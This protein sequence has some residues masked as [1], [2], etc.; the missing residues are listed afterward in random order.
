MNRINIVSLASASLFLSLMFVACSGDSGLTASDANISEVKTTLELDKCIDSLLGKTV[1]VIEEDAYYTCIEETWI[2][3]DVNGKSSSSKQKS[4]SSKEKTSSSK[5]KSSSSSELKVVYG[6]LTDIRDKRTYKTVT[7]GSQTWMAENL[8]YDD[9]AAT[10]SLK[11]KSWCYDNI[12]ANC[13][14]TGRLYTWAAA[15]DSVKLAND[16]EKS[17]IC[18]YGVSCTLPAKVQGIC[19]NGWRLPK[20]DDWKTLISLVNG[21]SSKMKNTK[22]KSTSG[23]SSGGNGTNSFGFSVLPTGHRFSDGYFYNAGIEASFWEASETNKSEAGCM[24]FFNHFDDA[25]SSLG[26][27]DYGFSVRCIEDVDLKH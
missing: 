14:K 8:N 15:I 10:P 11:G 4:S 6:S 26:D 13:N 25:L 21:S 5:E 7:I 18:G 2:K 16:K 27:K 17:Q 20:F 23:W 9:S 24:S 22:L 3:M 12:A 19:P 1:F